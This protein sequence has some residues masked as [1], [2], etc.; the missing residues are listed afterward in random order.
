M[1]QGSKVEMKLF[2]GQGNEKEGEDNNWLGQVCK[3]E[4]IFTVQYVF[5]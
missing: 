5:V 2:K 4:N 1:Q 3:G